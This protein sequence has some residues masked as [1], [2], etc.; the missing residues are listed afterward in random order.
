MFK[1]EVIYTPLNSKTLLPKYRIDI[2][3]GVQICNQ[4]DLILA[5]K[6]CSYH[7]RKWTAKISIDQFSVDNNNV[8]FF[9][10]QF[11]NQISNT[12]ITDKIY[13]DL[14]IIKRTLKPF[15]RCIS[16][17]PEVLLERIIEPYC[18]VYN[19]HPQQ[20]QTS[21]DV[22]SFIQ[23]GNKHIVLISETQ[24][25]KTG[26]AKSIA[27]NLINCCGYN[28]NKLYFIC[29]MNDN[30][31]LNQAKMEFQ[32]LIPKE[33]IIF[34][35]K[36]QNIV[37]QK[38]LNSFDFNHSIIFVDESHYASQ[39]DSLIYKF[40]N[41]IVGVTADGLSATWSNK[42]VT[43]ISIS[44]T[45]MAEIANLNQPS[46][47]K[48]FVI[49]YPGDDYYGVNDILNKGLLKQ[50]YNLNKDLEVNKFIDIIN[51]AYKNQVENNLFKYCIV[52]LGSV[53]SKDKLEL[54]IKKKINHN[55]NFI[56]YYS[57]ANG[58]SLIDFNKIIQK[59][60]NMMSI[61]WI[62]DSLRAGKQM[63]TEYLYL[64]HDSHCSAPDVAAQGLAGRLC[65]YGK[66]NHNVICYTNVKSLMK[67][68]DWIQSH[69]DIGRIPAGSKDIINGFDVNNNSPWQKNIPIVFKMNLDLISYCIKYRLE[70]GKKRYNNE[71]KKY[72]KET[73]CDLY[74]HNQIIVNILNNYHPSKNGGFMIID[75]LN[76]PTS[77]EKHWESNYTASIKNKSC[78][79]FV[80]PNTIP[81]YDQLYYIFMNLIPN[82]PL[83]GHGLI[84]YKEYTYNL[85]DKKSI[86]ST[87][88]TNINHPKAW[89]NNNTQSMSI[90][91]KITIKKKIIPKKKIIL[92]KENYT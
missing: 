11:H 29:G 79:G 66:K 35:K 45:P 12:Y 8:S 59:K 81:Q 86:V 3:C 23:K 18:D 88:T 20:Y 44:A 87:K 78:L 51:T 83:Y 90:K 55:I 77:I 31:L 71:F 52:R 89:E 27:Y 53:L 58:S 50:S 26:C 28:N 9:W 85:T 63:N 5:N 34:S 57:G 54:I 6:V 10:I 37:L 21:L 61:I 74:S 22:V 15:K 19:I 25:G 75:H 82:H 70:H 42:N 76:L 64:V 1:L 47:D 39:K 33:N 14:N 17:T 68:I 32:D 91:P 80:T 43:I 49:L 60:P 16:L 65:G 62:Y 73:L 56:N 36:L 67:F 13:I 72:C 84:C 48:K 41:N 4:T 7:E 69:Y 92:K 40:L 24:T 46:V 38:S 30:G 2:D